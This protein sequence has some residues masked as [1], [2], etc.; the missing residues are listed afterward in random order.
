MAS[1][2]W[3]QFNKFGETF[4]TADEY[5]AW[6]KRYS[7]KP[8]ECPTFAVGSN[9][10]GE[11]RGK[12]G[13]K[14]AALAHACGIAKSTFSGYEKSPEGVSGVIVRRII[15][16]AERWW[17]GT[18]EEYAGFIT[19]LLD[20][21]CTSTEWGPNPPLIDIENICTLGDIETVWGELTDEQFNAVIEIVRAM[22]AANRSQG[23][24]G[25]LSENGSD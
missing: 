15:D 5:N 9:A 25:W 13:I 17:S 22:V 10:I 4:Q 24:Q 16:G 8:A 2:R 14:Q 20:D 11:I 23:V 1:K 21:S 6:R 3:K 18:P 7:L 12:C 19:G